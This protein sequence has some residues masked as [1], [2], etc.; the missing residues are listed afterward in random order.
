MSSVNVVGQTI[1]T[2]NLLN[3]CKIFQQNAMF[4]CDTRISER[5]K[6]DFIRLNTLDDFSFEAYAKF[7]NPL[8]NCK[9]MVIHRIYE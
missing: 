1:Q 5:K 6:T 4:T 7:S 3:V 9:H 8:M 2:K